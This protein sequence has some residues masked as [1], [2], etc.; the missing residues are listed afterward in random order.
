MAVA[1]ALPLALALVL[2][3]AL[4]EGMRIDPLLVK[5]LAVLAGSVAV[6]LSVMVAADDIDDAEAVGVE[7]GA[8]IGPGTGT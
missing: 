6:T 7:R 2:A 4:L 3:L 1:V 5:L 8:K